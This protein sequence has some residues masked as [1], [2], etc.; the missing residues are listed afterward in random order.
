[1]C[2][3]NVFTI[4]H[5]YLTC[6]TTMQVSHYDLSCILSIPEPSHVG[7]SE[8]PIRKSIQSLTPLFIIIVSIITHLRISLKPGQVLGTYFKITDSRH[9]LAINLAIFR[10]SYTFMTQI[11]FKKA[12]CNWLNYY[13][14]ITFDW[15]RNNGRSWY[16]LTLKDFQY[17]Y[18]CEN[19]DPFV[20]NK[21]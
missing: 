18:G 4:E 2:Q 11:T 15:C 17:Q 13:I 9:N 1:M 6:I 19:S 8:T 10:Q 21:D 7:A 20:I 3:L 16:Y 12:L 14:D 5:R